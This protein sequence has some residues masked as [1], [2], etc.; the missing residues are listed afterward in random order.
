MANTNF[1]SYSQQPNYGFGSQQNYGAASG[2]GNISQPQPQGFQQYM[3]DPPTEQLLGKLVT[4]IEE[5]R[6]QSIRLDGSISYFP[7]VGNHRI[8]TKQFN[9][10]GSASFKVYVEDNSDSTRLKYVTQQELM[11]AMANMK[12]ALQS[13]L[14]SFSFN[15]NNNNQNNVGQ[16]Q[17]QNNSSFVENQ[18]QPQQTNPPPVDNQQQGIFNI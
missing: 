6:A 13:Y 12:N 4:S 16:M 15:N 7:D 3:S 10:D 2:Y 14:L 8:Y 18:A 9:P 1:S 11:D 5:A 17:P